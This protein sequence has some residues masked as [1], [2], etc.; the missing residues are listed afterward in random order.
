MDLSERDR[1]ACE[2]ICGEGGLRGW[3]RMAPEMCPLKLKEWKNPRL[4]PILRPPRAGEGKD[5]RQQ[6]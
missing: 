3:H 1:A 6:P 5:G 2:R 4:A